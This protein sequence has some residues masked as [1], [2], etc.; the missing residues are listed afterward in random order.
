[1]IVDIG[2]TNRLGIAR[3]SRGWPLKLVS[4]PG[5]EAWLS[6]LA[7]DLGGERLSEIK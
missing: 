2:H 4:K 1:M 7:T 6:F 3:D 5:L